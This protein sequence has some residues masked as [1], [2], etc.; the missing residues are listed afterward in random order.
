MWRDKNRKRK[1]TYDCS[2]C[3]EGISG[4]M[5]QLHMMSYSPQRVR[6]KWYTSTSYTMLITW[7]HGELCRDMTK[8]NAAVFY[9]THNAPFAPPG[10][11][12]EESTLQ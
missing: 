7:M 11:L 12:Q 2:L 3:R 10:P 4:G 6:R 9:T 1:K 8:K 5:E